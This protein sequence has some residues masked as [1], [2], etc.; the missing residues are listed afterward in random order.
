[1]ARGRQI[2]DDNF[3]SRKEKARVCH[4]K[5]NPHKDKERFVTSIANNMLMLNEV[6][7]RFYHAGRGIKHRIPNHAMKKS[8]I[9]GE[10]NSTRSKRDLITE[11]IK[12]RRNIYA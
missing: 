8:E 7:V 4:K 9:I 6:L 11:L 10:N 5:K 12:I 1:M 2:F 3:F